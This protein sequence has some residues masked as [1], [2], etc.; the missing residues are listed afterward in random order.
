MN[1]ESRWRKAPPAL[2]AIR[3]AWGLSLLFAPRQML[4]AMGAPDESHASRRITQILGVRHLT[5]AAAES[6]LAG[7]ARE[8]GV[9]VDIAHGA[10]SITF[11]WLTPRWRRAAFTDAITA[12]SF[13]VLGLV[14]K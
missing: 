1:A 4:R 5:E 3:V 8:V 6:V 7:S 13:A 10:T 14:N 2:L 11:A 9:W 12:F